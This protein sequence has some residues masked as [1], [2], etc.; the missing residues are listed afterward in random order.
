MTL[1]ALHSC[2]DRLGIKL[3]LKLVVDAPIGVM[4]EAVRV[5]LVNHK[6]ALLALLAGVESLAPRQWESFG[7]Q[8]LGI[9]DSSPA[10]VVDHPARGPLLADT[11]DLYDIE[12]RAAIMEF[13]G[14]LPRDEAERAAKRAAEGLGWH[15]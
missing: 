1:P 8:G 6:P 12:E 5:A 2:L 7:G 4:T 9:S 11:D 3:S 13:D 14:E 15:A 10:I